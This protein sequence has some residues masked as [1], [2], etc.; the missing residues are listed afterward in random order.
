MNQKLKCAGYYRLSKEDERSNDESSSIS[1][2]RMIVESFAKF[3]NFTLVREYVD[4]GYSG[5]NFD[6]P[7][8]KQ[9]IEDIEKGRVNC[10]ITKDL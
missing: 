6:R 4:D 9:M 1:S 7:G 3:N 10:V 5:G 2:Q 8:F